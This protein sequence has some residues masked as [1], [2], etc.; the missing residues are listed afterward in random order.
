MNTKQRDLSPKVMP[1]WCME[2]VKAFTLLFRIVV[3][4]TPLL[5]PTMEMLIYGANTLLFW[6][7][8]MFKCMFVLVF[9]GFLG[10]WFVGFGGVLIECVL[11]SCSSL[12]YQC[13]VFC[14]FGVDL[15]G[16]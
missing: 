13:M 6:H 12:C 1:L 2:A 5:L 10:R 7:V 16:L 8:L 15:L 4:M 14:G 3:S 9:V 11:I